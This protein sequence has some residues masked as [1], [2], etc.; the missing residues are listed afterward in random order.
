[1]TLYKKDI[2]IIHIE[3]YKKVV[4]KKMFLC[5]FLYYFG[6]ISILTF[7]IP[8]LLQ[9]YIFN[10][11]NLKK[12]YPNTQW[13]VVTGG[14]SGIGRAIVE[15]LASQGINVAIIALEDD[16]FKNMYKIITKKYPKIKFKQI[17]VNLAS[18]NYMTVIKEKCHD[19]QPNLIFNNAGFVA[20]GLFAD[21]SLGKQIANYNVNATAPVKI[22][23]YFLNQMLDNKQKGCI[24]FTSSPAGLMLTPITVMY[25]ATKA[26]LTSFGGSLAGEIKKFN[27]D[28]LVMH[29]S[30]VNTQFYQ[31]NKHNIGAMNTFKKTA[32]SPEYIANCFFKGIGRV[33]IYEQGYFSFFTKILL[34][35]IDYDLLAYLTSFFTRFQGDYKRIVKK[36]PLKLY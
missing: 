29:P 1:M 22:T 28:V 31:G 2:L 30:P 19:I 33:I 36:R 15:K 26:F 4:K 9:R 24:C 16:L 32:T 8:Y 7:L 20:T 13:A 11:Q 23:H 5:A 34:K 12:K 17:F 25:G 6:L 14:S 21:S 3:R 35:V 10:E 27:I 18:D